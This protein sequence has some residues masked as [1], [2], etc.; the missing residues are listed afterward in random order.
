MQIRNDAMKKATTRA[1]LLGAGLV[2]AL[3]VASPATAD[4][5]HKPRGRSRVAAEPYRRVHVH[6]PRRIDSRNRGQ[7]RDHRAGRVYYKPHHHRHVVYRFPVL[8]SGAVAYQP[9][10]YCGS[11]LFLN[12]SIRLPR[13]A[14]SI[15]LHPHELFPEENYGYYR[16]GDDDDDDCDDGDHNRRH[17]HDDDDDDD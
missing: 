11:D 16:H 12:A 13:L 7:Y 6:V 10:Y 1:L 9:Y 5:R 17:H 4:E 3:L 14:I 15:D 2:A 8:V